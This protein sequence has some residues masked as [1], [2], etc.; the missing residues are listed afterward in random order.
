MRLG[1]EVRFSAVFWRLSLVL[2]FVSGWWVE[3]GFGVDGSGDRL[4]RQL[5]LGYNLTMGNGQR[6]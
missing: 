2:G 6:K 5:R 4:D 3:D 1:S